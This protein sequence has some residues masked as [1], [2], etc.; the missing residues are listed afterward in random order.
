V[1]GAFA[2]LTVLVTYPLV[3]HLTTAFPHDTR[4]PGLNAWVLAW[5]A[6]R[7]ALG[8][9]GLFHPPIF[10]PYRRAL[11]YSEPLLGVAAVAA[12]VH[13]IGGDP[14]ATYNFALLLSYV[15]SGLGAYGLVRSLT[16]SRPAAFIAATAFGF[17]PH[18]ATQLDHVQVLS[19]AGLPFALWA[20]H[21]Y[22]HRP[23]VL[24]LAA[25]VAAFAWLGLSHGYGFFYGALAVA[26][27]VVW[28][29]ATREPRPWRALTGLA[30]GALA[31]AFLLWPVARSFQAVWIDRSE[32]PEA[33]ALYS[34]DLATYLQSGSPLLQGGPLPGVFQPEGNF[35][36]GLATM[37]LAGWAL[38]GPRLHRPHG[39]RP[40]EGEGPGT[41]SGA[42]WLYGTIGTVGILV[43][44]GP[45]PRAAGRVLADAGPF[46]ALVS[47]VPLF[48]IVRVPARFGMLAILAAA[49]LAG[50]GAARLLPAL[51]PRSRR[52]VLAGI[53]LAV[54]A[55]GIAAPVRMA[56]FTPVDRADAAMYDWLR[57]QPEG[58]VLELP[59][60]DFGRKVGF[61]AQYGFFRHRHPLVNG[62]SRFVPPLHGMLASSASPFSD[63]GRVA[64]GVGL[65]QGLDVRYL[66]LRPALYSDARLARETADVLAGH[67][68]TI[69]ARRFGDA[70][71]FVL[72]DA[73]VEAPAAARLVQPSRVRVTASPESERVGAA[74]D[75]NPGTRWL[76]GRAQAGT[77]W[78]VLELDRPTDIARLEI[79]TTARSLG[80]YPRA[81]DVVS[82]SPD[83][84]ER[85]L[86]QG[87]VLEAL[88]RAIRIRPDLPELVI[89]L[90]PN[91]SS[92]LV[93]RQRGATDS[94][95]WSVDELRVWERGAP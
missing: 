72:R 57:G 63:S 23:S 79:V 81:L 17:S 77:E 33:V 40:V 9:E 38:I 54:V 84:G 34:A 24:G 91:R 47:L 53:L 31:A 74:L 64:E 59:M 60:E 25:F 48:S 43:S 50:I 18:R 85:L 82:R 89:A 7:L 62:V 37:V 2:A 15:L 32:P 19:A 67:P 29:T 51:R 86:R 39:S 95:Y 5:D 94:W 87:P 41:R 76:S 27:V 65:L 68:Q 69:E 44:L 70:W 35:F 1:A 66:V 16:G 46:T 78:M 83:G 75:G 73:E 71:L 14:I 10:H 22:F 12:P 61:T 36:P 90:P 6:E 92:A 30:G 11:V 93:L 8:L 49:V 56:P 45:M 3:R 26:A 52:M 55:E 4:D 42:E 20:L 21:R 13:W 58:A 28:E 88:G 80:D